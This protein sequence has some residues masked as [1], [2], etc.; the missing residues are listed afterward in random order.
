MLIGKPD[1]VA[2]SDD[3]T[4]SLTQGKAAHLFVEGKHGMFRRRQVVAVDLPFQN[5]RPVKRI[6][7]CAPRRAFGQMPGVVQQ[8]LRFSHD[9]SPK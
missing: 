2:H 6:F 8:Q 5:I 9:S 3:K 4:A 7:F 1:A